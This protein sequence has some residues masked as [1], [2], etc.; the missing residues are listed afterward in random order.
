MNPQIAALLDLQTVDLKILRLEKKLE[1][2]PK[3]LAEAQMDFQRQ[4]SSL[5]EKLEAL[6]GLHVHIDLREDELRE[7]EQRAE[8][9]RQQQLQRGIKNKE[10]QALSHEIQAEKA[11]AS[12]LQDGI[13]GELE[14]LEAAKKEAEEFR[15]G[16]EDARK[17][18]QEQEAHVQKEVEDLRKALEGLQTQRAQAADGIDKELVSRYERILRGKSGKA[19]VEVLDNVCQGCYM[20]L[21]PQMA[22]NLR[23]GTDIVFCQSCARMLYLL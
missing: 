7:R 18:L 15:A 8:K 17:K 21:T 12:F 9:L 20:S 22:L 5:D 16:V 23:S 1:A 19:I 6:K 11:N 13:L 2:S 14:K 10:Y 3:A 4:Q